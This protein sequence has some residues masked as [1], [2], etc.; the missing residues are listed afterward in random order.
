MV[1]ESCILEDSG[2]HGMFST[3]EYFL[4]LTITQYRYFG[5]HCIFLLRINRV[6]ARII[7]GNVIKTK[8]HGVE[9]FSSDLY[10][11]TKVYR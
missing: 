10:G 7:Y 8:R 1:N 6:I 2:Q 11:T 3:M 4:T 9:S 5:L